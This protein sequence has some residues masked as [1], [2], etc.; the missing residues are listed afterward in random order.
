MAV[1]NYTPQNGYRLDKLDNVVYLLPN[2]AVKII[3]DDGEAYIEWIDGAPIVPLMIKCFNPALTETDELDERYAFTH[4]LTFSVNNYAN[5]N[6]FR[7]LYYAVIKDING[8]YW[9]VNPEFPAK[10]TYLYTLSATENKTDFTVA[11][12][13]N[14]PV[15]KIR[16][17]D[18][19]VSGESVFECKGY[20]VSLANNH[21]P[22]LLNE[23][24]F[25]LRKDNIV[26]YTNDGYKEIEYNKNSLTF[27]EQFDGNLVSHSL[28]FKIRFDDY[29]SSWHYNLLEFEK[30]TYTAVLRTS[31]NHWLVSGFEVGYRPLYTIN[32]DANNTPNSIEIQLI[33]GYNNG[34]FLG[35]LDEITFSE[36]AEK[37]YKYTTK[38]H[39]W[40]CVGLNLARYLL[41]EE[42]DAFGNLTGNYKCRVGYESE[43]TDL[44]IVGTF[45]EPAEFVNP[46][47][48]GEACKMETSLQTIN[49]NSTGTKTYTLKC[50]DAWNIR[51]TAN[52]I[53]VSPQ[54]GIGDREY[55]IEVT[56]TRQ[57]SSSLIT[58]QIVLDYC[59]ESE[60]YNV[61][62]RDEKCLPVDTYNIS[63]NAQYL[64][65]QST[66]CISGATG[67]AIK[68][69]VITNDGVKV[70]VPA[71]ETGAQTNYNINITFC[72]G[73]TDDVTIVQS[74]NYENWVRE[75]YVCDGG[76]K[77]EVLYQYT[78]ETPSTINVKTGK[79]KR[80]D[81][82]S[83]P[84]GDCEAS[85]RM[86]RWYYDEDDICVDG[87]LYQLLYQ[88]ESFDDGIHW[89][90]TGQSK[91]GKQ[92]PDVS[93]TC[94]GQSSIRLMPNTEKALVMIDDKMDVS[95][96]Y[97]LYNMN[98]MSQPPIT[99]S[100]TGYYVRFKGDTETEWKRMSYESPTVYSNSA[101]TTGYSTQDN[102][103]QYFDVQLIDP[104][105]NII[106]R[107]V[108]NVSYNAGAVLEITDTIYTRVQGSIDEVSGVVSSH[109]NSISTMEQTLSSITTTVERHTNYIEGNEVWKESAATRIQQTADAIVQEA[110]Y[111]SS[112]DTQLNS[113]ITQTASA[114]TEEV[115]ARTAADTTLNT[116]IEQ[117]A[118][119]ITADLRSVSGDVATNKTNI[120][121]IS[122][123]T[124][125]ITQEVSELNDRVDKIGK[126][127]KEAI[128]SLAGLNENTYYPVGCKIP[129]T[130]VKIQ[131]WKDLNQD[132][133]G[134]ASW[135]T[136]NIGEKVSGKGGAYLEFEETVRGN[137]WG[138]SLDIGRNMTKVEW[139]YCTGGEGIVDEAT[140]IAMTKPVGK[141]IQCTEDSMELIH[142]RGGMKYRVCVMS[143]TDPLD[144]VTI[145]LYSTGY[146]KSG[147]FTASTFTVANVRND[148]I[149]NG[150]HSK[151]E[152]MKVRVTDASYSYV[153]STI[154]QE[155]SAITSTVRAL[156][157]DVTANTENISQLKQTTSSITSSVSALTKTIDDWE[158]GGR[159][160][161]MNGAFLQPVENNMPLY[162]QSWGSPSLLDVYT[163]S[164][165]KK[166]MHVRPTSGGKWQGYRQSHWSDYHITIDGALTYTLSFTAYASASVNNC[167]AVFHWMKGG[168]YIYQEGSIVQN[169][170]YFDLTTEPTQYKVTFIP[171]KDS[172]PT[173]TGSHID[174]FEFM[175][176][177]GQYTGA[178][179]DLYITDIMFEQSSC[180]SNWYPSVEE[181]GA[182]IT[183]V[184]SEIQQTATSITASIYD[185]L[186]DRTGIDVRAG[187]ITLD[188]DNTYINGNPNLYD[189]S[190]NGLTI[191]DENNFE[192][193]Y[194]QSNSIGEIAQMSG[195]TQQALTKTVTLNS[196]TNFNGTSA[197]TGGFT[198]AAGKTLDI[199][200]IYYQLYAAPTTGGTVIY[201]S[202]PTM[203]IKI[204]LLSGSSAGTAVVTQTVN[205]EKVDNYGTYRYIV[206]I[207]YNVQSSGTFYIRYTIQYNRTITTSNIFFTVS[208][209]VSTA[210]KTETY[211][212]K[213]GL[214]V[215]AGANKLLWADETQVQM[216]YDFGGIRIINDSRPN[217]VGGTLQTIVGFNGT[218]PN[219]N[220]V[221]MPFYNYTPLFDPSSAF[222]G[223]Y[224]SQYI[225]NVRL[226]RY[227]YK[228]NPV[229][230]VGICM[231]T[232]P[233][234]DT[235]GT[236]QETWIILPKTTFT[237]NGVNTNLP[238]GYSITI[239]NNTIDGNAANVYVVPDTS[240]YQSGY[241]IDA[242]RDKNYYVALNDDQAQSNSTFIYTGYGDIWREMDD[243][244]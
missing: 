186:N 141:V 36:I 78:G 5:V 17:F 134:Y 20:K 53:T 29:K 139:N 124:T 243:S 151:D 130:T 96:S 148:T 40:E 58:S 162:W 108:V 44:N 170:F 225:S 77:Y 15:L 233:A 182:E 201:P 72:D 34:N 220:P 178:P 38:H 192:R 21:S 109:T 120:A 128:I 203:Q 106:D 244:Q 92:I 197:V 183:A 24:L 142:L 232:M 37:S 228:I 209:L 50:S 196:K 39:G 12:I 169:N 123:T 155:T 202:L 52:Y 100:S 112:A 9:M 230:D 66:C 69:I 132:D 87:L 159:N 75:G 138:H 62:L 226:T 114:I 227:A 184:R 119:S 136:H 99:A 221:W 231:V 104:S 217:S 55:Q 198:V 223:G 65:I 27:Q 41:A 152:Y 137:N 161:I 158:V 191:Y 131:V 46:N 235:G 147:Y 111:R 14:H 19:A 125:G 74:A 216:R 115:S 242:N 133:W 116:K 150:L 22:L 218:E 47:C 60:S 90:D 59:D 23:K 206:P 2:D 157:G 85:S 32:A 80:G 68:N 83:D 176:G 190:G 95:L 97:Y 102:P 49:F 239:V 30:N 91:L 135:G 105:G 185:E 113:R 56:N 98:D 76:K 129:N 171:D 94:A 6:L 174:S 63:A 8:V 18:D 82:L 10:V 219:R 31:D 205:A 43:F 195:D 88:Q 121:T 173:Y 188:A 156:S 7:G 194:I 165:G 236:K 3:I 73:S 175:I 70:F 26:Y 237:Y 140:N 212:G 45:D 160:Y 103:I 153:Y 107:R 16:N 110:S 71:N 57:P 146:T 181:Q 84:S 211:I 54:S 240:S 79:T 48:S 67:G 145:Q 144:S 126:F 127:K 117:T 215:H 180:P 35:Y 224:T 189:S 241:I 101:Y 166:W 207:R 28:N 222:K 89:Q 122:A 42:V 25:S 81:E 143:D 11:T 4:S 154:Q 149:I 179:R 164:N 234:T 200:N 167:Q 1:S 33:D 199:S 61:Y 187:E 168:T 238:A 13:S 177:Q 64:T 204:E 208:S 213:D 86:T 93:G 229:E 193:V 172:T 51:S 210:N 163:D 214:Y 118:S